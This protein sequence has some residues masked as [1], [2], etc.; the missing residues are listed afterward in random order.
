MIACVSRSHSRLEVHVL[1]LL[2]VIIVVTTTGYDGQVRSGRYKARTSS[3][4]GQ[5]RPDS[6]DSVRETHDGC[7]T[8]LVLAAGVEAKVLGLVVLLQAWLKLSEHRGATMADVT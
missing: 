3:H 6:S 4:H 8:V 1:M 2:M 5:K 7:C